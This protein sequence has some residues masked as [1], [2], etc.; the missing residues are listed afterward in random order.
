M[1]AFPRCHLARPA[2]AL[3][4]V[5]VSAA[6]VGC[7]A[8]RGRDVEVQDSGFLRNYSQLAP[9]EG[10]EAQRVYVNPSADWAS[11]RAVQI[12]SVTLWGDEET[13]KLSAEDKQMLTDVLYKALHEKLGE[14]FT[15][16]D[17]PAPDALRL[18][19][20]LTGAQGSNIP[21][22]VITSIHPASLLLGKLG[23]LGS[24]T[25][26]TVGTAT[27]EVEIVDSITGERLAAAVDERAGTSVM[28][29]LAPGRTFTSWGDVKAAADYWS[30]R[31]RDF[32]VRQGVQST[33][34]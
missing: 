11:F 26:K 32:L 19:A 5:A 6:L 34:S 30:E 29:L 16:V 23:S 33:A 15:I 17:Q 18:R 24:D 10:Y 3:A 14:K 2:T 27:V 20:A 9:R 4:V 31:I 1:H 13:A 8:T 12:D 22:R 7:A 21:L 25:A 28:F